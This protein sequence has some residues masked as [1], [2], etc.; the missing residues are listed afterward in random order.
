MN[1]F[2]KYKIWHK[3]FKTFVNA[4]E[5]FISPELEVFFWMRGADG[6]ELVNITNKV[7]LKENTGFKDGNSE[8]LFAGDFVKDHDGTIGK[9]IFSDNCMCLNMDDTDRSLI[10]RQGWAVEFADMKAFP[11]LLQKDNS[12][13]VKLY[14]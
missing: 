9:I 4:G 5:Y 14:E 13:L 2:I 3:E 10:N 8:Y 1:K 11:V 12:Q 7:I 6:E